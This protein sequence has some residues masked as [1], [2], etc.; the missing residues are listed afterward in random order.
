MIFQN[1]NFFSKKIK[2]KLNDLSDF[3]EMPQNR[4]FKEIKDFVKLCGLKNSM[5]QRDTETKVFR[6][7]ARKR[8]VAE[9]TQ[10]KEFL[11]G[12]KTGQVSILFS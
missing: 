8:E 2:K 7:K 11:T 9:G 10:S 12:F 6:L 3:L 1:P 5:A 4:G